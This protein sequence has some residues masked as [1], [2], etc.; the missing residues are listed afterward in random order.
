MPNMVGDIK[1]K[2]KK[3]GGWLLCF[4]ILIILQM[5]SM[6]GYLNGTEYAK[7]FRNT[8]FVSFMII[9]FSG[10]IL[11]RI[12]FY[13]EKDTITIINWFLYFHFVA[14]AF[15]AIDVHVILSTFPKH[16][17][18]GIFPIQNILG[19]ALWSAIWIM[20]FKKSERV[21]DTYPEKVAS[22]IKSKPTSDE[23]H[24]DLGDIDLYGIPYRELK[25]GNVL[26]DVFAKAF[27]EF[28]DNAKEAEA[29]Y[30]QYRVLQLKKERIDNNKAPKPGDERRYDIT[31]NISS[32]Q[33][34]IDR[35]S[36][37]SARAE[38][39]EVKIIEDFSE[40]DSENDRIF[41]DRYDVLLKLFTMWGPLGSP[42]DLPGK[43]IEFEKKIKIA[44]FF[45]CI[46]CGLFGD[47]GRNDVGN[48][49]EDYALSGI[50]DI[51]KPDHLRFD[52]KD[53][54]RGRFLIQQ[55]KDEGAEA[56]VM[57]ASAA[58]KRAV[59]GET[60]ASDLR[61]MLTDETIEISSLSLSKAVASPLIGPNAFSLIKFNH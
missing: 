43:G 26:D 44:I 58:L 19:P 54:N 5:L 40:L 11:I 15:M 27:S 25:S 53:V 48:K 60:Q 45:D 18:D 10:I 36:S 41:A 55:R 3:V 47:L 2:N 17:Y 7:E 33:D 22:S 61:D 42:L 37:V 38:A 32:V 56:V 49:F 52:E 51:E 12:F 57:A 46:C 24:D 16:I 35:L 23:D 20:Y 9:V 1:S 50:I 14:C 6:L 4:S 34:S 28:P 8:F 30:I 31:Q 59:A 29:R 39:E 13:K 21:R